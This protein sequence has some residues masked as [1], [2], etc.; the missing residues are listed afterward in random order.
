MASRNQPHVVLCG[1]LD[2]SGHA[3]LAADLHACFALGGH[4]LP[5]VAARTAQSATEWH[6]GWPS[7]P[8]ELQTTLRFAVRGVAVGA[9]KTGM[10][11]TVVN[12]QTVAQWARS[13]AV[14]LVVDPL[15]RS[16]SGGS[17]WPGE[18]DVLVRNAL[19]LDLLP[20]AAVVTPNWLELAWLANAAPAQDV[21]E[22]ASQ[23]RKL[24]CPALVKGG[25]AP[26]ALL[27]TDWVWD[28]RTLVQLPPRS[29]WRCGAGT[30][31]VEAAPRGTGCRLA[32]AVAI[33][34]G[35]GLTLEQ[36]AEQAV[37]WLDSWARLVASPA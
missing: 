13:L 2:P 21:A 34:L 23:V 3:G 37:L 35:K 12:L 6:A 16:S 19:L 24:P 5:V 27:G 33:G 26:G 11:G 31:P 25:H 20:T 7:P 10:L 1:G 18:R 14:P 22:L 28:R 36:A 15:H 4:G 9:I 30:D 29:Q 17:L 8:G 32:T